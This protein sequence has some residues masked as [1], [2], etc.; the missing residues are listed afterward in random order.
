MKLMDNHGVE[1]PSDDNS[2]S[3]NSGVNNL[4]TMVRNI[5][6]ILTSNVV[7]KGTSFVL[8]ALVARYLGAFEFG[9]LSLSLTLF[10]IFQ[11]F[12]VAGIKT[13]ITREITGN[14]TLTNQYLVNAGATVLVFSAFTVG[15]AALFVRLMNYNSDTASVILLLSLGLFPYTLSQIC[16]GIFQAW[17]KMQ[18]IAYA[19]VSTN[20]F[21]M[22]MAFLLLWQGYGLNHIVILIVVSNVILFVIE[23]E[24]IRRYITKPR[25][26]VSY[27]FSATM[28]RSA[29]PFLGIQGT[30][31]IR[32]N[33][34]VI[35]LSALASE[36]EIG[37]YSAAVQLMVPFRLIFNNFVEGVFPTM[38]RKFETGVQSLQRI[39]ENLVELLIAIALPA[40]VGL[41]VL[42][43]SVILMLYGNES[44][45]PAAQVLQI[46]VWLPLLDAL[47]SI[48]G[49]VLWA[50]KH[51]KVSL[52]IS[53][54]N[55]TLKVIGDIVLISQFGLLGA[56]YSSVLVTVVNFIQHYWQITK[57]LPEMTLGQRLWKPV[58]AVGCMAV[59]LFWMPNQ[60]LFFAVVS[61]SILY[62]AV[63][64][65]VFIWSAGGLNQFKHQYMQLWS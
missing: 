31:A 63:L 60:A 26:K 29:M 46:I 23:W 64:S 59:Y 51:E 16:E 10:H 3:P 9:Q 4:K 49:Q 55:A 38:C 15:F 27:H 41:Y 35:V 11:I 2:Q 33:L 6:S 24:L 52:R 19:N 7:N 17:E 21:T 34:G 20:I 62:G 39:S 65:V 57:V 32:S 53:I 40:A 44:F 8:Y 47:K 36:T 61:G 37:I 45:L 54:T 22:V 28:V 5:G 30:N 43:E 50:S 42:S 48:F 58:L 25:I 18:Y 13:F 14:K 12:A 1:P 56:A